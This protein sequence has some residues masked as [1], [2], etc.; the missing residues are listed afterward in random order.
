MGAGVGDFAP[1]RSGRIQP[2]RSRMLLL[3]IRPARPTLAEVPLAALYLNDLPAVAGGI[4]AVREP[5][6]VALA[7]VGLAAA[8]AWARIRCG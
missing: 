7:M 8:A 3:M 1:P 2:D 4:T 5:L 6:A